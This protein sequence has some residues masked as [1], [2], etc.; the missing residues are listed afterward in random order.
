[1]KPGEYESLQDVANDIEVSK[2]TLTYAYENRRPL[3]TRRK[4]E[5]RSFTSSG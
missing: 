3:I 1:M 2:E 5:L 4:V